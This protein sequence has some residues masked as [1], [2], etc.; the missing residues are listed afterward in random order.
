[1]NA[2]NKTKCEKCKMEGCGKCDN[3]GCIYCKDNYFEILNSSFFVESC[4]LACEFGKE[5][6]CLTC[7]TSKRYPMDTRIPHKCSSCNAGYKL[8][9]GQCKKIEN[10]FIAIYKITTN[11]T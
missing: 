11:I 7:V 1:M 5:D 4:V 10:S 8:I 3:T 9:D 2:T 6:K